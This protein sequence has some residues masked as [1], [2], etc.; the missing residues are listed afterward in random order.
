MW[1]VGV[2]VVW[3]VGWMVGLAGGGGGARGARAATGQSLL[4]KQAW[5]RQTRAQ[6]VAP[7]GGSR[8]CRQALRTTCHPLRTPCSLPATG[9]GPRFQRGSVACVG[10]VCC[11]APAA[12][13]GA[14]HAVGHPRGATWRERG[15]AARRG[16]AARLV[17]GLLSPL[18]WRPPRDTATLRMRVAAAVHGKNNSFS[19]LS[20][21]R[22]YVS[23]PALL[24]MLQ[25]TCMHF[26]FCHPPHSLPTAAAGSLPASRV[27]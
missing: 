4:D 2:S 27:V 22:C 11:A 1:I 25:L 18:S 16:P 8:C 17:G 10:P 21:L 12:A 5:W 3:A 9:H 13:L 15:R 19:N 7:V 23:D 14:A 20:V 24:H 6:Y 26:C